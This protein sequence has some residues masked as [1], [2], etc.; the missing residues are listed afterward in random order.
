MTYAFLPLGILNLVFGLYS[1]IMGKYPG[2]DLETIALT[3]DLDSYKKYSRIMG[4]VL[5]VSSLFSF[6]LFFSRL[7]II[8][9]I[10]PAGVVLALFIITII[11][12]L[13][14]LFKVL[15]KTGPSFSYWKA[16]TYSLK[17]FFNR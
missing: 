8:P 16:M 10:L 5:M 3:Y 17:K 14:G 9:N 7:G 2:M 4:I 6:Q 1:I 12:A 15:K 13:F 11:L